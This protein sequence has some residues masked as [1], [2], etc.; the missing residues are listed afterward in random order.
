M[1]GARGGKAL[2]RKRLEIL[3]VE[4]KREAHTQERFRFRFHFDR[5]EQ[6]KPT[7]NQ[8]AFWEEV[9]LGKLLARRDDPKRPIVQ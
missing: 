9:T 4:C 6:R 1:R 2:K 3:V 7:R 5:G 8:Q